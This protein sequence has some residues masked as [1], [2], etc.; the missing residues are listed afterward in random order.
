MTTLTDLILGQSFALLLVLARVGATFALM[1][2]LGESGAPA[3]LKAGLGLALSVLLLPVLEPLLPARPANDLALALLIAA[4]L[5]NGLWFG[6]LARV[7][8]GSLPVAG[9]F[10]ADFAGLSNVLQPSPDL[11]GQTT[12]IA[13]LYEVAVPVL[14]LSSGLYTLPLSALAGFY[15]LVPPGSALWAADGTADGAALTVAVV[16]ESFGLAL[17]LASPFLLAAIAWNTAIGLVAR[18]VPRLQIYFVAMPGQIGLALLLLAW[19]AAPLLGAWM[20][21]MRAG[22]ATLPG[23]TLPGAP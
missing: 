3:M 19:V 18:L 20:E 7:L 14:V 17:R 12:A 16:A 2:G 15:R 23:V 9:Q 4:E 13:R 8:T 10:I 5:L 6:W 1:P 21:A 22:F 11:G